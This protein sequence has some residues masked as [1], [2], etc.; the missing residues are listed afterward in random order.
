MKRTAEAERARSHGLDF[1]LC[2][3][4][5]SEQRREDEPMDW[6]PQVLADG[7][8]FPEGP[9]SMGGGVVVFTQIRGARLSRYADGRVETIAQ[10]GGGA[11]GATLGSDG[12]FYVANNGGL[13]AGPGG[14]SLSDDAIPGR[15]QRVTPDG[16]LS[17]VAV[18]LPGTPPH[19]PNDLC[20]GPDGLLYF[21]DPRNWEDLANLKPG[22]V[23]RTD[24]EGNVEQLAEVARFP[25]GIGFGPDNRLYVAETIT[26][27]VLVYDWSP[28]GLGPA[29]VFCSLSAGFPDGFCFTANGDLIVC[30]SLGDVIGVFGRDGQLKDQFKTPQHAEPT[31][32]CIGDGYL[33]T[34]YSGTGQL[35]AFKC[36]W[37]PLPLYPERV[38]DPD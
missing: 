29:S 27:Q 31:N 18:N 36:D 26:Q 35:V 38:N 11:N 6:K 3:V 7:L 23:N 32:C 1:S 5:S 16:R 33:Y 17:D 25:N 14:V 15:I 4:A 9:V 30:G 12:A 13:S 28:E 10:T 37:E 24:L 34:T 20:F 22:R 2:V 21:T 19:R 8:E